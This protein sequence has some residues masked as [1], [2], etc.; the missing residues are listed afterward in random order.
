M[1]RVFPPS[2]S[3]PCSRPPTPSSLSLGGI[4]ADCDTSSCDAQAVVTLPLPP[5][6]ELLLCFFLRWHL[7]LLRLSSVCICFRRSCL[8]M[9]VT[10]SHLLCISWQLVHR[11]RTYHNK[12]NPFKTTL[13]NWTCLFKTVVLNLP[14]CS[15]PLIQSPTYPKHKIIFVAVS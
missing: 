2:P 9:D 7:H 13:S 6:T 15:K 8:D 1:V 11:S 4:V 3:P 5:F 12:L 10:R 14:K